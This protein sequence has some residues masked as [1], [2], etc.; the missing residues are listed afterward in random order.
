MPPDHTGWAP[1]ND[2]EAVVADM[3]MAYGHVAAPEIIKVVRASDSPLVSDGG[4]SLSRIST[5]PCEAA[6]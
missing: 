5:I 2:L 4:R 1:K 3:I 6:L